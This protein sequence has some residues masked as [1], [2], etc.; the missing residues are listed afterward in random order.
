MKSLA[1]HLLGQTRSAVLG[2]L[3]LR[4]EAALHVREL[5]RVT[6]SSPGSLHRELAALTALGLLKREAI[7]RQVHYRAD[8]DSP[9]YTELSGLLR[10]TA[11]LADV[12]RGA[13]APLLKSITLAFVYGSMASGNARAFSDV[14]VMVLGDASFAALVNALAPTQALLARE[15]N[16]T[17]MRPAEFAGKLRSGDGFALSVM[18]REKIWLIGTDHDLAE[19]VEDRAT[20][21]T[22]AH[23]R[24]DTAAARRR[25]AQPR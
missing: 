24:R 10:K 12:L 25:R 15:V 8:R 18:S 9:V 2:T 14:D 17:P 16:V 22:P 20:Q 5:A 1:V 7:G 3:L 21:G 23:A 13:L 11:G 6:G 4:P 19:L